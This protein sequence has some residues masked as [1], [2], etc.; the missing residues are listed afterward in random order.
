MAS[1]ANTH[2]PTREPKQFQETRCAPGLITQQVNCTIKL[3][4]LSKNFPNNSA[5][6]K[7]YSWDNG[8]CSHFQLNIVM[9]SL[10]MSPC[11]HDLLV[12]SNIYVTMVASLFTVVYAMPGF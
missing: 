11:L 2:T 3:Y 7:F 9:H 5:V 1:G 6:T 4:I 10:V 12:M 8:V